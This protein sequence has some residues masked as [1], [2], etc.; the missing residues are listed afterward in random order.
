MDQVR[1]NKVAAR[2]TTN[3]E[4]WC[5][6]LSEEVDYQRV[7]ESL[8][9]SEL[10]PSAAEVQGMFCGLLCAGD[11][12]AEQTW[13]RELL[14][15][16]PPGDLLAQEARRPLLTLAASTREQME[17]DDLALSLLLPS[18]GVPLAE[19]AVAVYDW[20]RGFLFG[21]AV[22]GLREA[23]LSEDAR[24]V[25]GDFAAL[26]QMDLDDLE[27]TEDNEQSLM[28]VIEFMRVA[29]MLV[30]AERADTGNEA[31]SSGS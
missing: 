24:G 1:R 25:F 9:A 26:T 4:T 23:D 11:P 16:A 10:S 5:M 20:S 17:S 30:Y 28:E 18:D 21:L 12:E 6:M 29:A 19:R 31:D 15:E 7:A 14:P 27:D 8:S 22:A 3:L 2:S 13:L